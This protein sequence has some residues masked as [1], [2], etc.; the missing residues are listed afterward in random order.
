[1]KSQL[2]GTGVALITPFT[3]D[4]QVDTE[5]L[6]RI[7]NYV[8][9]GGVDFI[10]ALGTTSEAPTL[11]KEEKQLVKQT[12]IAA[13][14]GRLPLV[15]GIGGNNTQNV[16]EEI[17][18]TDLS[19]FVAILSVTPYYNKPSQS[20]LYAHFGAIARESSLPI[21]LYNV[22]GRTGVSMTAET[23]LRLANDFSNII[24]VKEASGNMVLDMNILKASSGR[25]SFLSGD[26]TTT[27]LSVYMGGVGAISVIGIA[28]PNEFSRMVRLGLEGKIAEANKLQYELLPKMEL[29]F[30]EGNPTGIKAILAQKGLCEPYVRLPLVEASSQLKEEIGRLA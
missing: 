22:P 1:M 27:L 24:A 18:Q 29:A 3:K 20:G 7:V 12:I 10:V 5:A 25:F 11:T 8:I 14:R 21:I 2:K 15:I 6:S 17:K 28:Y 26:D 13:N 19:E 23:V 4:N 30:K 9:D 16:I